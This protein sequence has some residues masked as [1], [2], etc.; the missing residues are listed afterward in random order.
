MRQTGSE[1]TP[2]SKGRKH[3]D[4]TWGSAHP[5]RGMEYHD[6]ANAFTEKYPVGSQ[7]SQDA[8]AAF[9]NEY[10]LSR[11][12]NGEN[13]PTLLPQEVGPPG[14]PEGY[15]FSQRCNTIRIA[16]N[17]ASAH[18]RMGP[19]AYV[20]SSTGHGM[21]EVR[22]V[23]EAIEKSI[24]SKRVE[25]Y[26]DTQQRSLM[27]LM[28][29]TDWSR[30]PPHVKMFLENYYHAYDDFKQETALRRQNIGKQHLNLLQELRKL[31]APPPMVQKMLDFDSTTDGADDADFADDAEKGEFDN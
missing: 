29:S 23:V 6:M 21:L 20:V 31:E 22:S 12:R 27:Y 28:Q 14:T 8:F 2:I 5:M 1:L 16:M 24:S 30:L 25:T 17:K 19:E 11:R 15:Y 3:G 10:D 26:L 9:V 13:T 7:L 18:P 4:P